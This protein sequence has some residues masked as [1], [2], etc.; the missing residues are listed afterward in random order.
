MS[1]APPSEPLVI[2]VPAGW[3]DALVA[4]MRGDREPAPPWD[5]AQLDGFAEA[6]GAAIA[7][8]I[9]AST[10]AAEVDAEA[11]AD[12]LD[13]STISSWW[14][15]PDARTDRAVTR[16]LTGVGRACVAALSYARTRVTSPWDSS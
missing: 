1:A 8:S 2:R 13:T 15:E 3:L 4:D 10:R 6:I 12:I 5:I 7:A 11:R 9:A 14:C 16:A